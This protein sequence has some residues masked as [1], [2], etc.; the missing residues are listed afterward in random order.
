MYKLP[1]S[2][3]NQSISITDLYNL[4]SDNNGVEVINSKDGDVLGVLSLVKPR[5]KVKKE[6]TFAKF[7]KLSDK[8]MSVKPIAIK[9]TEIYFK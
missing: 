1:K 5:A 2:I 4:V 6:L 9:N 3:L 7:R 8:N